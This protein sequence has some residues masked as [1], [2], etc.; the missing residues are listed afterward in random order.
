MK[1]Q[2]IISDKA[3]EDLRGIFQH[4]AFE[5]QSSSNAVK[6]LERLEAEIKSLDQMPM[7]YPV[8]QKAPWSTRNLRVMPVNNYLVF[9]IADSK[10]QI[11]H[12]IRVMYG[13]RNV[14]AELNRFVE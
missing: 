2:V 4:I 9:Y 6:Q 5:L 13:G 10:Q 7:R 14:E 1:Y 8:Y 12:V 3:N 11:V